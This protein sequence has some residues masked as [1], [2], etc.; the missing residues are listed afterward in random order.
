MAAT[1]VQCPDDGDEPSRSGVGSDGNADGD[2]AS[3]GAVEQICDGGIER[4]LVA[5]RV[6]DL[7]EQPRFSVGSCAAS[8]QHVERSQQCSEHDDGGEQPQQSEEGD[9]CRQTADALGSPVLPD[10]AGEVQCAACRLADRRGALCRTFGNGALAVQEESAFASS[11]AR[12]TRP[13]RSI[14][15]VEASGISST[16]HTWRGCA[17]AG[18]LAS[19]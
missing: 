17:Y 11:A 1:D 5:E 15:A 4:V 10:L 3:I 13:L 14:F 9:L 16:N 19:A 12:A 6:A 2:H 8:D 18:P 7:F